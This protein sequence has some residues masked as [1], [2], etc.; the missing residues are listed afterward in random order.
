MSRKKKHIE[1]ICKNCKLFNPR[2]KECAVVVLHEGERLHLP[3][4]AEDSCFFEEEFFDPTTKAMENFA[5]DLKE[6]KFWVE[7]ENGDKVGGEGI[8]KMEYPEGFLG[9]QKVNRS[10]N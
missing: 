8:V 4:D 3:V 2:D 9:E 1:K 10:K 6:V 5:D 7:N